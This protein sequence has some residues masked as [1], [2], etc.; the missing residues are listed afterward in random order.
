VGQLVHQ[1]LLRHVAQRHHRLGLHAGLGLDG[2]DP[3]AG[4]WVPPV[5]ISLRTM[6]TGNVRDPPW[7]RIATTTR[8]SL[9]SLVETP[10]PDELWAILA[11]LLPPPPRPW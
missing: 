11:P 2:K 6:G 4:E 7:Y 5:L 1:V 9:A 8:V 10:V 3:D